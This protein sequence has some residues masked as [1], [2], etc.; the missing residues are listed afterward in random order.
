MRAKAPEAAR[1]NINIETLTP[2]PIICPPS[3][4]KLQFCELAERLERLKGC[5]TQS[6]I[7]LESLYAVS[8][9]QAFKGALD[10]SRVLVPDPIAEAQGDVETAEQAEDITDDSEF[11]LPTPAD[12]KK[13]GNTN[14]RKEVVSQWLDAYALQLGKQ[15]FSNEAFISLAQQKLSELQSADDAPDYDFEVSATDYDHVKDCIFQNL[16][17]KHVKQEYDDA[18]NR[19]Q[20]SVAED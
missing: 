8:S 13:L 20:I 16:E 14:G 3:H 1:A 15:P 6:I 10:L 2:L 12:L 7:G 17:S 9:Q 18:H 11:E 5:Y 19:V 4:L